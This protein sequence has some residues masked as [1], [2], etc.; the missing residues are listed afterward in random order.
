MQRNGG[1]PR[2]WSPQGMPADVR[3]IRMPNW[4][5][6]S[7]ALSRKR[8]VKEARYAKTQSRYAKTHY[9]KTQG[10]AEPKTC[11][12]RTR[13]DNTLLTTPTTPSA[14][15]NINESAKAICLKNGKTKAIC[16]SCFLKKG[17]SR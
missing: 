4:R 2:Q 11:A 8:S 5:L 7:G 10:L 14:R 15:R 12:R 1:E 17:A 13:S 6:W 16:L 3:P 9:Y